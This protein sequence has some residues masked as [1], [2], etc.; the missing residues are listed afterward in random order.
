MHVVRISAEAQTH[1]HKYM[2]EIYYILEGTGYLELDDQRVPVQPGDA[3]MI[4]PYCRHRAVGQ[5]TV[6]NC[7]IPPMD[8]SDEYVV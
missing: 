5:L 7:V 2:T 4:R 3:V 8:E 6:L 1:Y